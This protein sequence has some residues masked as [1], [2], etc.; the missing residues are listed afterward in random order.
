[1]LKINKKN[2][3]GIVEKS[4]GSEQLGVMHFELPDR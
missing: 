2:Y 3:L 4:D 1:M